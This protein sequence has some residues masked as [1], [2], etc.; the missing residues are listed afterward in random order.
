MISR[1]RSTLPLVT[2]AMAMLINFVSYLDRISISVAA[3]SIR[4]E[5]GLSSLQTGW[6]FAVFSLSYAFLQTPWGILADRFESR[7][8]VAIAMTGWSAFT[9]LTALA[10][11]F[12]SLITIRFIFGTLEAG[13]SPAIAALVKERISP[14]RRSLIF[15]L[16]LSGGRIG[17]AFAPAATAAILLWKGWR[18]PFLIFGAVGVAT[19]VAWLLLVHRCSDGAK[20]SKPFAPFRDI[21][22]IPTLALLLTVL[23]YTFMWQF[24]ATW[25][26]TYIMERF[27]YSVSA[28]GSYASLPFLLGVAG[29]WLGGLFIDQA[30]ASW[31]PR[32]G[33]AVAGSVAL[34]ASAITLTLGMRDLSPIR[35][36]WLLSSAAGLGDIFLS[37]AWVSAVDLG[38]SSAAA[39]SGLMNT[40]SNIGAMLSPV[41]LGWSREHSG[42]WQ[43]ALTMAAFATLA[44]AAIWPFAN[45][46]VKHDC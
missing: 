35:S 38:R 43:V 17:G 2:V 27:H 34:T 33:R 24:F 6:V 26:P 39:L 13:L 3:P 46:F 29:N 25:F 42:G 5:F 1:S 11:N 14:G 32:K 19:V 15:G 7:T 30:S 28:A 4:K 20:P 36:I 37:A 23:G 12:A 40:A 44:S 21:P 31:G 18:A 16:F 10:S 41:I 8:I 22:A 45:C 9:A